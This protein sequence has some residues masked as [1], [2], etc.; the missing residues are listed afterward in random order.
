MH[1]TLQ[2]AYIA[3]SG[4]WHLVYTLKRCLANCRTQDGI[5]RIYILECK[6]YRELD[7]RNPNN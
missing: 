5:D 3:E 2:Q 7:A 1:F 6:I 4:Y